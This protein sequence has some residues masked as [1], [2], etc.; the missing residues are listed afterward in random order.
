LINEN[1]FYTLPGLVVVFLT[2]A[3][4]PALV[5]HEPTSAD[6][7]L[8][9]SFNCGRDAVSVQQRSSARGRP[10]REVKVS[11]ALLINGR[12]VH[13]SLAETLG[14]DMSEPSAVFRMSGRCSTHERSISIH[15]HE[16]A[17]VAD[18]AKRDIRYRSGRITIR[19]AQLVEYRPLKAS[20]E[21]SF[22]G[23]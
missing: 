22:W 19:N 6:R 5:A 7:F 14:R 1:S 15:I 4:E 9:W 23:W 12:Q 2:A 17:L 13:S 20:N 16:G 8:T 11:F 10:A 3:S 21:E 18:G